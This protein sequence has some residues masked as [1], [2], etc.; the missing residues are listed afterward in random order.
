MATGWMGEGS[1]FESWYRQHFLPL[2]V[3]QVG[4]GAH[5]ASHPMGSGDMFPQDKA[6]DHSSQ[7]SAEVK[8]EW[9]YTSTPPRLHGIV[10]NYLSTG[11]TLPLLHNHTV[12]I[13]T[14]LF[15]NLWLSCLIGKVKSICILDRIKYFKKIILMP[16]IFP[17]PFF[18]HYLILLVN[19]TH[20]KGL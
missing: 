16:G 20:V 14:N 15:I 3:V 1:E 7:T 17:P 13:Y 19:W 5:P 8:N 11:T 10:H 6:G 4:S 18:I 12:K 2:H 9:L